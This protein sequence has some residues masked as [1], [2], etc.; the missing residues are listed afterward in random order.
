M[1]TQLG[2]C[3]IGTEASLRDAIRV[4][5][6]SGE[7]IAQVVDAEGRLVGT[8]TDRDICPGHLLPMHLESPVSG[9]VR[10]Q[11]QAAKEARAIN[12]QNL[13]VDVGWS[14]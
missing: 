5:V 9:V 6:W 13:A 1:R 10:R 4:I 8:L 2:T 14:L 3:R 12:G 7:W 11:F